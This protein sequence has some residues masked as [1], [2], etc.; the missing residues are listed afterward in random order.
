MPANTTEEGLV[1]GHLD[2]ADILR[3]LDVEAPMPGVGDPEAHLR[4]CSSCAARAELLRRRGVALARLLADTDANPASAAVPEPLLERARARARARRFTF[5]SWRAAAALFVAASLAAQPFVRRWAG[6]QWERM[7][8]STHPVAREA[9]AVTPGITAPLT[10]TGSVLTFQPLPGSFTIR[11]DAPP[12]SGSLTIAR[13]GSSLASVERLHGANPELVVTAQSLRVRNAVGDTLHYRVR[14]PRG[15]V[16]VHVRTGDQ[17]SVGDQVIDLSD[18]VEQVVFGL[19]GK[20]AARAL[21]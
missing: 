18:R 5:G 1:D 11:F 20:H 9:L 2:D 8:G 12:T 4:A 3:H 17:S 15:V 14:F 10:A 19:S 21:P 13:D 16:R 7:S 6:A